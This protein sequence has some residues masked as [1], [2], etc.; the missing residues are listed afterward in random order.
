MSPR[1]DA[2]REPEAPNAFASATEILR[3]VAAEIGIVREE[4][5]EITFAS[6]GELVLEIIG[7]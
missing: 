6:S 4:A 5:I 7:R 2:P 1:A 3:A